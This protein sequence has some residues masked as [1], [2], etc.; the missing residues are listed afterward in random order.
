MKRAIVTGGAGGIGLATGRALVSAGYEV[1]LLDR[2]RAGTEAAAAATGGAIPLAADIT[3]ES[4]V[5]KAIAR[6]GG[7]IHLLVNNAGIVRKGSLLEQPVADFR[8]VMDINLVGALIMARAVVPGMI[9]QGG[10]AIVNVSSIA[11]VQAN[12]NGGAYGPSKAALCNL[13]QVMAV[14]WAGH[15]IRV[16]A[17]APGLIDGGMATA[18]ARHPEVVEARRRMVPLG[19]LGTPDAVADVILFLASDAARYVTGQQ[20]LADGGLGRSVLASLPMPPADG[21]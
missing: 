14:E 19:S 16:N 18:G 11:A 20:L 10:G 9:R 1:G 5:A 12:A 8:A 17:V 21:V 15:G 13:T 2:D 3:D 6:F 4:A 7:P